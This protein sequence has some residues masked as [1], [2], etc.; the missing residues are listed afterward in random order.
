MAEVQRYGIHALRLTE[1][2][3]EQW[4]FPRSTMTP[5]QKVDDT[6]SL[7]GALLRVSF[8]V[9]ARL[10]TEDYEL[11]PVEQLSCG[12]LREDDVVPIMDKVRLDAEELRRALLS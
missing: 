8:E 12:Q 2:A 6:E 3:L 7:G 4:G 1:V 11:V 9:A 5:L 10:T